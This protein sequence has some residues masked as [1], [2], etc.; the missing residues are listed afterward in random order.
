MTTGSLRAGLSTTLSP[1][2]RAGASLCIA[3]LSGKLNGEIA[4]TGPR[5]TWRT[6]PVFP[7]AASTT[8][9]GRISPWMRLVSSAAVVT[10]RIAR[11]TSPAASRIGL[12][13][14]MAIVSASSCCRAAMPSR[15]ASRMR[16]RS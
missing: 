14:S 11:E 1:A 5:G 13:A 8:S 4:S 3:R 12:P 9:S 7:F 2:A 6:N 15:N 16:A 10:V